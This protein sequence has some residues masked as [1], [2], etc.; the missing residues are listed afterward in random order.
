MKGPYERHKYDLRRLWECPACHHKE[1]TA[2]TVTSLYCRC[3]QKKPPTERV[4]MKLL[5]DGVRR[6]A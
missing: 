3:Q 5:E 2:G 4:V 1:R 6:I